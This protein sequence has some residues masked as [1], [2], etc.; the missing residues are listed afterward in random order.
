MDPAR[1]RLIEAIYQSALA[2]EPAH[3]AGFL[4]DARSLHRTKMSRQCGSG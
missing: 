2:V 1:W 4:K 3:R